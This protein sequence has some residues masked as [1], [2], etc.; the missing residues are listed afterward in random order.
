[1]GDMLLCVEIPVF[2]G[3]LRLDFCLDFAW[4]RIFLAH[5]K[6]ENWKFFQV[7]WKIPQLMLS[8]MTEG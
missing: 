5:S 1:M 7:L 8:V 3:S 6:C 4:V 2:W